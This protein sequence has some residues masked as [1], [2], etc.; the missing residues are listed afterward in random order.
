VRALEELQLPAG[1]AAP[2]DEA[3]KLAD[4]IGEAW[5]RA[6]DET[7]RA[8]L[9]TWFEEM[10]LARDGAIQM[11]AREPYKWIIAAALT[12]GVRHA[13]VQRRGVRTA[14]RPELSE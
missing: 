4:R 5:D 9:E 11:V 7:R 10:R 2:T 1:P 8:F 12:S 14:E 6:S 3:L 13:G